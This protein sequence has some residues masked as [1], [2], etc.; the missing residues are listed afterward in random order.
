MSFT[1]VE[2]NSPVST[3]RTGAHIRTKEFSLAN[4]G[5]EFGPKKP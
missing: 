5:N 2:F 1:S 4:V 3:N